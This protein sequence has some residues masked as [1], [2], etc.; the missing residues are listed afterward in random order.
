MRI[1]VT[2][3]AGYVGCVTVERLVGAGHAVVVLDNLVTGHRSNP[4]A[5]AVLVIGSF[6]DRD[7]VAATLR[8]HSIEAVL[9]CGARSLV[10]Q[11]IADPALYYTENVIGG[12]RLLDA[13][14]E[15]G[16][17]RLV[18]SSTAAV[19]G[20][21]ASI[22]IREDD[23]TR[24]VNPYGETKVAAERAMRWYS[25]FGLRTISLRYFNVAGASAVHGE[26]HDPE[27]HLIPNIL[28][29]ARDGSGV[30]IFGDDY[31]TA[32][33]TNIRDY[34]HVLD[35]ADAH[36][37]AL[38]RTGVSGPGF[39]PINLG[40]GS[41]FSV[42]EVLRAAESVVGRPIPHIIGPRREGDPPVLIASN[43]RASEMLGWHPARGTLDEMIGSAWAWMERQSGGAKS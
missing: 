4:E 35:L 14:R 39:E 37:A 20:A 32:D 36:L 21:P 43:D 22:P 10:A 34:I 30:T 9:H 15:A 40:S 27:T 6:G 41:G 13:M 7:L 29:A 42:F 1:L 3:G 8:E 23:P 38:E 31:S 5:A 12:I 25:V 16:V 19:Y 17:D 11:S 18:F 28:A 26:Q 2:G 33:G 24:P